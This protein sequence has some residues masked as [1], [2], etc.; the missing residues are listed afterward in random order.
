MFDICIIQFFIKKIKVTKE[1]IFSLLLL[2]I[3]HTVYAEKIAFGSCASSGEGQIW[4][5]VRSEN[6]D[7][8]LLLGDV[9]Y[10]HKESLGNSDKI[11][12]Q[13]KAN[14]NLTTPAGQLIDQIRTFAIWD[15]H[16]YGPNNAGSEFKAADA[17]RESYKKFWKNNPSPITSLSKSLS[18]NY[19][20]ELYSLFVLDGRTYRTKSK[21]KD[22]QLF[23][24]EQI[25]WLFGSLKRVPTNKLIIIASGTTF[26]LESKGKESFVRYKQEHKQFL[27]NLLSLKR[28]VV[29]LSGDRHFAQ[30]LQYPNSQIYEAISSPLTAPVA[31]KHKQF[32]GKYSTGFLAEHNFGILEIDKER[33]KLIVKVKILNSKAE[34]K[35]ESLVQ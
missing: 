32:K 1:L 18:F 16:D 29:L 28:P 27:D 5:S 19:E 22:S 8:F 20:Q 3:A 25:D 34:T 10:L 2:L 31:G 15:D 26:L 13:L 12:E 21:I 24:K 33:E 23:G 17:T 14:Y 11:T 9:V 30:I 4:N 6:P 35:F 7:L